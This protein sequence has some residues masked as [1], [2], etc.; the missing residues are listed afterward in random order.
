MSKFTKFRPKAVNVQDAWTEPPVMEKPTE[1]DLALMK[2]NEKKYTDE[3]EMEDQIPTEEDG[4]EHIL[5]YA[6][7]NINRQN[8]M[9][10]HAKLQ[11]EGIENGTQFSIQLNNR[12]TTTTEYGMLETDVQTNF[13]GKKEQANMVSYMEYAS[14]RLYQQDA[15]G[16]WHV[17]SIYNLTDIDI[18]RDMPMQQTGISVDDMNVSEMETADETYNILTSM[19]TSDINGIYGSFIKN[20]FGNKGTEC[21]V[22]WTID[23]ESL[24]PKSAVCLITKPQHCTDI[25]INDMTVE[26]NFTFPEEK[27]DIKIPLEALETATPSGK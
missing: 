15:S 13:A 26:Y 3:T 5:D 14:D 10:M 18:N 23:K 24:L 7:Q 25:S 11:A 16:Q 6:L 19:N 12:L 9:L 22:M 1:D 2:Q 27:E 20:E 8:Y 21:D 17:S 4:P